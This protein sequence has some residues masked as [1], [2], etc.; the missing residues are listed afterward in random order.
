[1]GGLVV[2]KV[3]HELIHRSMKGDTDTPKALI[4]GKSNEYYSVM[5]SKVHGVMFLSTPHKGSSHA[6]T[7]NSLLSVMTKNKIYVSELE[8]NSTSIE[9]INEQFRAICSP[10]QLVS[11]YETKPTRLAHGIKKLVCLL[12]H[13]VTGPG[14]C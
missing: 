2:K 7:L 14:M 5:L 13:D 6:S 8:P 1:M 11:L 9:D 10:W 12:S 4:I 3:C